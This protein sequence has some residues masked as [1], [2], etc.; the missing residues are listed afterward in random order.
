MAWRHISIN[1]K[2]YFHQQDRHR[3]RISQHGPWARPSGCPF[4]FSWPWPHSLLIMLY[5][6]HPAGRESERVPEWAERAVTETCLEGSGVSSP[7]AGPCGGTSIKVIENQMCSLR[8]EIYRT[9]PTQP[10]PLY[11][12]SPYT[13]SARRRAGRLCSLG[14]IDAVR[15]P[16]PTWSL[17]CD[18]RRVPEPP[19]TFWSALV[20]Q[21]SARSFVAL[22]ASISSPSPLTSV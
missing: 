6:T 15:S 5:R 8:G 12:H 19:P 10:I 13:C 11:N 18:R 14:A 17:P 1:K 22:P 3:S 16:T 7:L 4:Q 9:L 2:H 21:C 20:R